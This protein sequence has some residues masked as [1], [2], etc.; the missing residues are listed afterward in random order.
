LQKQIL[1][2]ASRDRHCAEDLL[3]VMPMPPDSYSQML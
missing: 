2:A 3:G 1:S